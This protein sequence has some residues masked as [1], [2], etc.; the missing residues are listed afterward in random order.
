MNERT[1]IRINL[2]PPK[3]I[4]RLNGIDEELAARIV[5]YRKL[6]MLF[7][8]P[9]DLTQ[10]EGIDLEMAF[11]M[12]EEIDWEA[13]RPARRR[14]Y[15]ARKRRRLKRDY[16]STGL[17]GTAALALFWL[18]VVRVMPMLAL[19]MAIGRSGSGW[20]LAI[21]LGTLGMA[22]FFMLLGSVSSAMLA[23]SRQL[24][25]TRKSIRVRSAFSLLAVVSL[26]L[27]LVVSAMMEL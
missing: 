2:D 3:D 1:L 5:A 12:A 17:H 16:V 18:L 14:F 13:P 4:A 23:L 19:S 26:L 10:V 6:G 22:V 11:R 20:A 8:G 27:S 21:I 24:N 15:V 7:I 25:R 9:E